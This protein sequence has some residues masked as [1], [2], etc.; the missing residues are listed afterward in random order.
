MVHEVAHA[1]VNTIPL[2]PNLDTRSSPKE[3]SGCFSFLKSIQPLDR[4]SFFVDGICSVTTEETQAML[5]GLS[6]W[7]G[8]FFNAETNTV[9][10]TVQSDRIKVVKHCLGPPHPQHRS[11]PTV[12]WYASSN[13]ST[14]ITRTLT[15]DITFA[16]LDQTLRG[17][18]SPMLVRLAAGQEWLL[19]TITDGILVK[20]SPQY[21]WIS[22]LFAGETA[23]IEQVK[24]M[25][26]GYGYTPSSTGCKDIFVHEDQSAR[27]PLDDQL[28]FHTE[29]CPALPHTGVKDCPKNVIFA[30]F[31]AVGSSTLTE[32]L[33]INLRDTHVYTEAHVLSNHW[34]AQQTSGMSTDS[35][36]FEEFPFYAS[37]HDVLDY[38]GSWV[39]SE[40]KDLSNGFMN[41]TI[42]FTLLRNPIERWLSTMF[43][44]C[45]YGSSMIDWE[46]WGGN[47]TTYIPSGRGFAGSAPSPIDHLLMQGAFGNMSKPEDYHACFKHH[48]EHYP[49]LSNFY[50]DT[51]G[52]IQ[53][54][55]PT[56][57]DVSMAE[58]YSQVGRGERLQRALRA[59]DK[60]DFIG[61]TESYGTMLVWLA[62]K[63]GWSLDQIRYIPMR[64]QQRARGGNIS[65]PDIM[66][67]LERRLADDIAVYNAAKRKH[68]TWLAAQPAHFHH[69]AAEF[70]RK[71]AAFLKAA[72][73]SGE[74]A[75][76]FGT[77]NR[78]SS[79]TQSANSR[80]LPMP[81]KSIIFESRT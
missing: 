52:R 62:G 38:I 67:E 8:V 23:W 13:D 11:A 63:L 45:K 35:F 60:F 18:A 4:H 68:D 41:N 36:I 9:V 24:M 15:N 17:F 79:P 30:R 21:L 2:V 48:L 34:D 55:N 32:L 3:L 29:L 7:P 44:G 19:D 69:T 53:P 49:D 42:V 57:I 77:C 54:R 81:G 51:L 39:T 31:F 64:V 43:S 50:T 70:E 20:F 65:K 37:D 12:E 59:V 56:S 76:A 80:R 1:G 14:L 40:A 6:G 66:A 72:Q 27:P 26:A 75:C 33:D 25:L 61:L 58:D 47:R 71:Q 5:R 16:A 73:Q 78:K 74:L 28:L 46:Q 22:G 10:R